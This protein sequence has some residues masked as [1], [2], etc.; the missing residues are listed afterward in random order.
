MA[1]RNTPF[2]SFILFYCDVVAR[3]E[4]HHSITSVDGE[5]V[6]S[7]RINVA[8][9]GSPRL[10]AQ[11]DGR[12]RLLLVWVNESYNERGFEA[13][14][15]APKHVAVIELQ[16]GHGRGSGCRRSHFRGRPGRSGHGPGAG[17]SLAATKWTLLLT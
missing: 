15:D 4:L 11:R 3:E 10:Q 5:V 12:L 7:N 9:V 16:R 14:N 1:N 2:Y 6:E 17:M 8:N 13:L